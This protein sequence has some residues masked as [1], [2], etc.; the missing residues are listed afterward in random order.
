VGTKACTVLGDTSSSDIEDQARL[1]IVTPEGWVFSLQI[2]HDR[3]AAL[4]D[5]IIAGQ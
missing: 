4:L 5:R 2:W 1:D 3:E